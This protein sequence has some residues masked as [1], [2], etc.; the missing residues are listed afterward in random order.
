MGF[1]ITLIYQV[2]HVTNNLLGRIGT[3]GVLKKGADLRAIFSQIITTSVLDSRSLRGLNILQVYHSN[4]ESLAGIAGLA[5]P[6]RMALSEAL[7]EVMNL[8]KPDICPVS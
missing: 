7:Q 6:R 3:A 2:L 8:K 4:N 5:A 1:R